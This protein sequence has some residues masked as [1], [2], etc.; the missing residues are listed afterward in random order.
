MTEQQS[1]LAAAVSSL[2]RAQVLCVGD[3]MLD[4]FVYGSVDRISPEAPIPVVRVTRE[5]A[6]LGGSG[7][8]VRN[9]VGL[10]AAVQFLS[11]VGDDATG[12]E[13]ADMLGRLPRVEPMLEVEPERQTSIK[14]RFIAGVQ[15]LLRADQET[16]KPL[17][18]TRAESLLATAQSIL[19]G[20]SGEQ[21]G[22][23]VLSD[24]GKGVLT[25]DVTRRL[26]T[27][28]QQAGV[29]VVVDPKG[30]DY[31]RYR[32]ATLVTPNRKELNEASDL[33]TGSDQE[34]IAAAQEVIE[35][36]GIQGVLAT[37]SQDGMTLVTAA[38]AGDE[39]GLVCHLPAEAREVFDVSGAGD[40]VIATIAAAL[41]AG[42]SLRDGAYLANVA[43]GIVVGKVGTAAV[44]ADELV[45]ALHRQGLDE[46]EAK[47]LTLDQMADQVD[48]W[49]LQGLKVGF[50]NGCFD[51][52]HPGHLS[53]LRQSRAACDRLIVGLNSDASVRG[54]K[55]ES[56]PVQTETARA[57]VLASLSM[58]DGVVIFGDP[59]PLG[60]IERLCPDVLVKGA[61]YTVETVVGADLV[62]KAGGQ[63]VLATL[64][65]GQST[66][67]TIRRLTGG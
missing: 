10:G 33:P 24:Y 11:L 23:L 16:V 36:C 35:T 38:Q 41:A 67:N 44:Q 27:M 8:V 54:L 25:P 34:V 43:A 48:R 32:G 17:D 22:V 63:V 31:S 64:E 21:C 19:K 12:R 40:T 42:W 45:Q 6:M 13:V 1:R 58:V 9:L 30:R 59:T 61:D 46:A 52:L 7:N 28:A 18:D 26:I 2:S 55:G 15:Q 60:L 66:T 5:T 53:L 37:R 29:P 39:A 3:I 14:T 65:P 47:V 56:R 62:L 51:L 4:R 49:R 57:A 20:E 50:T